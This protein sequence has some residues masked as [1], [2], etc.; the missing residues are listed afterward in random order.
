L[1]F[2]CNVHRYNEALK[3]AQL[4]ALVFASVTVGRCALCILLTHTSSSSDWLKD[5]SA[6]EKAE[7]RMCRPIRRLLPSHNLHRY[8]TDCIQFAW[9][10]SS[11]YP[12]QVYAVSPGH[13]VGLYQSNP[14]VTHSL[15]LPGS[16][17]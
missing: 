11:R 12:Y 9:D 2:E 14:L 15:K 16:N 13:K 7:W 5:L 4:P 10:F 3:Q 1:P 8:V 6:K 17:P